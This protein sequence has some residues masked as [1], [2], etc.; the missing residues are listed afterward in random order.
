M[1]NPKM[2]VPKRSFEEAAEWLI[3]LQESPLSAQ[4]QSQF[5]AWKTKN[6]E[7]ARAWTRAQ[8]LMGQ[9]D[10]L[11]K[12]MA[13]AI[14]NRPED[15]GR[16]LAIGKLAILLAAG[17]TVWGGYK[18]VQSQQWT[19]DYRTT[20]GETKH[21]T[22]PDGSLVKLNTATAFDLAFDQQARTLALREGE[23]EIQTAAVNSQ[24]FGP[25][26]IYTREG[27]LTPL[28][29]TFTV[30]QFDGFTQLAVLQGQVEAVPKL[31]DPMNRKIIQA[32]Y[33][34]RLSSQTILSSQLITPNTTAWLNNML[35]AHNMPLKRFA[36]EVSR[37]RS[38]VIRVSPEI[39]NLPISGAF[40][41]TDTDLI[42]TMLTRTYPLKVHNHLGGYWVT[43]SL[44]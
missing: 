27:R 35:A 36:Q 16:R 17:P 30:R 37:Y 33:Q 5:D 1:S 20:K 23:I 7:N 18:T 3:R 11:P 19:A 44:A 12:N 13:T 22:L 4:E 32:G 2:A 43:L 8:Q 9:V 6:R 25:L 31:A 40:P 42:L 34:A 15:A 41:T 38:G 24:Q 21:V 26:N 14:L 10:T 39:E 29:T 28:G